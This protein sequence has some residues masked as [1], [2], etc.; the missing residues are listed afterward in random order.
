MFYGGPVSKNADFSSSSFDYRV[1]SITSIFASSPLS[2]IKCYSSNTSLTEIWSLSLLKWIISQ[3]FF[4]G[5]SGF[6]L[7]D[8]WQSFQALATPH[9]EHYTYLIYFQCFLGLNCYPIAFLG[10]KNLKILLGGAR[11]PLLNF[12]FTSY[13]NRS[14]RC[15]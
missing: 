15:I 2:H 7:F 10:K 9:S 6:L 11:F 4:C 3:L 8:I 5:R 12:H 1:N 14:F 13:H